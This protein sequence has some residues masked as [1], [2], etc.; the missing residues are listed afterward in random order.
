MDGRGP[1]AWLIIGAVAGY[2]GRLL[3]R[4]SARLGC[5]GTTVLGIIGSLVGGTLASLLF[6]GELELSAAGLIGSVIG[7]ILV[8][9]IVRATVRPPLT[10]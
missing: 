5:I 9:I 2:L 6:A 8:L 4:G 3:V 10:R 7:T 1:L